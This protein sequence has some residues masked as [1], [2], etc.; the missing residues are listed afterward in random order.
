M[1]NLWA[2]LPDHGSGETFDLL[3]E[4]VD[5]RVER[6][7]S[8]GQATP[9]GQW[10]EQDLHEWVVVLRGRAALRFADTLEV[11]TL[12]S[13]DH[14]TIPAHRRHRVEWTDPTEPTVWLAVHYRRDR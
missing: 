6:I 12:V 10:Y 5:V 1:T 11:L 13:G 4:G 14:V 9:P 2:G 7:V 3:A 8:R